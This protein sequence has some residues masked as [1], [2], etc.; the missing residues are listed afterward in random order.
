M[1]TCW[2]RISAGS[3]RRLAYHHLAYAALPVHDRGRRALRPA[4]PIASCVLGTSDSD[5]LRRA[6]HSQPVGNGSQLRST[7]CSLKTRP[8]SSWSLS[9]TCPST[10]RTQLLR[11]YVSRENARVRSHQRRAALRVVRPSKEPRRACRLG[12]YFAFVDDDNTWRPNHL[13]EC[14]VALPRGRRVCHSCAAVPTRRKATRCDRTDAGA[15]HSWHGATR[16]G[17]PCVPSAWCFRRPGPLQQRRRPARTQVAEAGCL[18]QGGLAAVTVDYRF[19]NE[20]LCYTYDI[21]DGPDGIEVRG[22]PI[23]RSWRGVYGRIAEVVLTRVDKIRTAAAEETFSPGDVVAVDDP[24]DSETGD[25]DR[26]GDSA[27]EQRRVH[28]GYGSRQ[29]NE[30]DDHQPRW[31][32]CS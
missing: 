3:P 2:A 5:L 17:W 31:R 25:V 12:R 11:E 29:G 26:E 27:D 19:N 22:K 8:T 10:A 7:P 14:R 1:G 13:A 9:T 20:S 23:V 15:T 4:I 6:R 21:V 18:F 28:R 32:R 30:R 24:C 16:T